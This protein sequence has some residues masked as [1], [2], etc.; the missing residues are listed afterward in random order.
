MTATVFPISLYEELLPKVA[1]V[2]QLTQQTDGLTNQQAKQKLLH[3]VSPLSFS[4]T[5]ISP[6]T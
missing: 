2:L 4:S 1:D 6:N 5:L 3:A